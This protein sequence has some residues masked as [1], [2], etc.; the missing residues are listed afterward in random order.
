MK[1]TPCLTLTAIFALLVPAALRAQ[2]TFDA[3]PQHVIVEKTKPA[4]S[5][6]S[7][8]SAPTRSS[9]PKGDSIHLRR[10]EVREVFRSPR[11]GD[12]EL[13]F[14]L[15]PEGVGIVQL[16]IEAKGSEVGY[17]LKGVH[18]GHTVGGAVDRRW[19]DHGGFSPRN[20][21]DEARIQ[22]AVKKHPLHIFVE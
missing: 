12:S 1:H 3:R 22:A 16:T 7:S 2:D 19:L 18:P 8:S 15:P 21:A 14:Y 13:A 9:E 6:G 5:A 17:F 4:P 11:G 10:G 20:P